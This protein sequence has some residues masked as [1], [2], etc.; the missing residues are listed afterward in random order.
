MLFLPM[1]GSFLVKLLGSGIVGPVLEYFKQKSS[2]GVVINGQNVAADV[3]VTQA[4][5]T[6]Y[7]EERKVVAQERAAQHLSPWTAWMIP[8]AFALCMLHYGCLIIVSTFPGFW[9]TQ[10]WVVNALPGPYPTIE[11][12]IIMSV[13]GVNGIS[14]TVRKVFSK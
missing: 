5:L 10:G 1:I 4:Q 2:D 8:T 7:V 9:F 11:S 14:A 13:I 12:A 6:A 3:S